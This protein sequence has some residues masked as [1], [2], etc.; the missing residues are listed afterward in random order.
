MSCLQSLSP[1]THLQQRLRVSVGCQPPP[2]HQEDSGPAGEGGGG[3]TGPGLGPPRIPGA[4]S[5]SQS[6]AG[7]RTLNLS[8]GTRGPS[9]SPQGPQLLLAEMV[10]RL[11]MAEG[12]GCRLSKPG[13]WGLVS[14]GGR[15]DLTAACHVASNELE[16]PQGAG[17]GAWAGAPRT[18]QAPRGQ[19]VVWG[20]GCGGCAL[21][22]LCVP[23][24][25]K[26]S[27]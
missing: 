10:S 3:R 22:V 2:R 21:G 13:A 5:G 23:V 8:H 14:R 24:C 9:P 1:R 27:W 16:V 15:R 12:G 6:P 20:S 17:P 25:N 11:R 4:G 18:S 7:D 19:S 26:V